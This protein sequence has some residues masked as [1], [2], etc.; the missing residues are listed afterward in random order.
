MLDKN[1]IVDDLELGKKVQL[2]LIRQLYSQG[3]PL[4]YGFPT[5]VAAFCWIIDPFVPSQLLWGWFVLILAASFGRHFVTKKFNQQYHL[6]T[7][8]KGWEHAYLLIESVFG[9]LVG[10][11]FYFVSYLEPT[12]QLLVFLLIIGTITGSVAILSPSFKVNCAF[13]ASCLITAISWM[14]YFNTTFFYTLVSLGLAHSGLMLMTS[15]KLGLMLK[16]S[17]IYRYKND[18]LLEEKNTI[19]EELLVS[20]AQLEDAYNAKSLFLSNISHEIRTPLNGIIGAI[21]LLKKGGDNTHLDKMINI[22]SSASEGLL[23]LLNNLL[24]VSK[25]ESQHLQIEKIPFDLHE[26]FTEVSDI[27]RLQA[28]K[29]GLELSSSFAYNIPKDLMGDPLRMRQILNNLGTN[30]I[31]FTQTGRID[32]RVS[33]SAIGKSRTTLLFEV[34]DTGIG[35]EP[36]AQTS[37]FNAFTQADTSTT[38]E[39][40]GTGLGLAIVKQLAKKMGGTSGVESRL[41]EGSTFWLKI[42]FLRDYNHKSIAATMARCEEA[43]SASENITREGLA[44]T[45]S[46]LTALLVED[47]EANR[48]IATWTLES[49]GLELE[50]AENGAEALIKL[51]NSTYDIIFMDC[52]MPVK[53]GFKAT[54]EMRKN[55]KPGEH[56]IIVAMTAN[57]AQGDKERCFAVGM[58]GYISKPI[59]IDMVEAEIK[60]FIPGWQKKESDQAS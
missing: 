29:K 44:S 5:A 57:A 54:Q 35:I 20:K 18:Q 59:K 50:I 45:N 25:N 38:R 7:S 1:S 15:Y 43:E 3:Y 4:I 13:L 37:I 49:L 33:V 41:G 31:K 39:F 22:A 2:E 23:N 21:D 60:K 27:L 9:V 12:Y 51:E 47:N 28:N 52:Q 55:E 46:S 6:S 26:L 16:R 36:A 42:P 32:L 48:L 24:D 19:N 40:G 8:S 10:M 34:E 17:L 58:D 11:S 56:A 14:V 53:D 30:A